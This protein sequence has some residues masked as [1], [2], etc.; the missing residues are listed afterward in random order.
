MLLPTKGVSTERALMTVGSAL[1]EA[2]HTP[3]S[4]SA[5]WERY[6][7]RERKEGRG[8]RVTFDWFSLALTSLFAINVV[9]WTPTGHLRRKSVH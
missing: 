4:V 1:L 5:L 9:E 2:L 8:E 3:K 6:Q 7:E